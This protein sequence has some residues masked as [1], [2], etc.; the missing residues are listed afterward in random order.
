MP[1]YEFHAG[2]V[3]TWRHPARHQFDVIQSIDVLQLLTDD[4][5]FKDALRNFESQLAAG[6]SVLVPMAFAP[7][8]ALSTD[9][10]KIRSRAFFD[11]LLRD[12]GLAVQIE[13][14]M[15]YW[16]IDGGPRSRLLRAI[17]RRTGLAS[18]YMI[19]RVALRLGLRNR[20]PSHV[21]SRAHMIVI[22]RAGIRA[23]SGEPRR[24]ADSGRRRTALEN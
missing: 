24:I 16:L 15:Y 23:R 17:F 22:G 1:L 12:V 13:F 20:N 3:S 4:E 21:L 8:G 6:G 19:D 7:D 5:A 9:H 18:L 10:Q 11:E 14:P 2:D